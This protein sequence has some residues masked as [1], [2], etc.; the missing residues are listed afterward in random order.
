MFVD[1][2][3]PVMTLM[4]LC[5]LAMATVSGVTLRILLEEIGLEMATVDSLCSR[6]VIDVL[7]MANVGCPSSLFWIEKLLLE[8]V[9]LDS[10]SVI[11]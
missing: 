11:V 1:D 2:S 10:L 5:A 8:M 6:T 4:Q 7:V 9:T 3:L